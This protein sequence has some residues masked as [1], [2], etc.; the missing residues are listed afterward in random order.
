MSVQRNKQTH[1]VNNRMHR[2]NYQMRNIKTN[3]PDTITNVPSSSTS[4][5]QS[6]EIQEATQL[7]S[8]MSA[9]VSL[10]SALH[11]T[12]SGPDSGLRGRREGG[13]GGG[14][15]G[16]EAQ[17]AQD[18]TMPMSQLSALVSMISAMNITRPD[19][20][21]SPG[22]G[23]DSGLEGGSGLGVSGQGGYGVR[24]RRGDV[25]DRSYVATVKS[26][27]SGIDTVAAMIQG[28]IDLNLT[29][30]RRLH[31]Q[32]HQPLYRS[33]PG[34]GPGVIS[35]EIDTGMDFDNEDSKDEDEN[36]DISLIKIM[37]KTMGE[38]G[39]FL[40]MIAKDL[41][42][43]AEALAEATNIYYN[44]NVGGDN[45]DNGNKHKHTVNLLLKQFL[46]ESGSF[47]RMFV[48]YTDVMRPHM[49]RWN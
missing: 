4:T 47:E 29:L 9:L 14:G 17:S 2:I 49:A 22:F 44:H 28:A 25:V 8:Q 30:Q 34:S 36:E 20:D 6:A 18:I 12:R 13:G 40:K 26:I 3:N 41:R 42:I 33:A 32:P 19:S 5:V 37:T 43:T 15:K 10:T 7:K 1:N 23:S 45:S 24:G 16:V 46:E 35:I 39:R 48:E 27:S 38:Y 31:L 11:I 21:F